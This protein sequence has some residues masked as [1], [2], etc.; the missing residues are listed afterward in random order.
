MTSAAD[1]DTRNKCALRDRHR[2]PNMRSTVSDK[3]FFEGAE[4]DVEIPEDP[5]LDVRNLLHTQLS[6]REPTDTSPFLGT[7]VRKSLFF[8]QYIIDTTLTAHILL[9]S[10]SQMSNLEFS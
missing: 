7:A 9:I 6:T 2:S 4:V 8:G 5:G 1:P 10:R 3:D